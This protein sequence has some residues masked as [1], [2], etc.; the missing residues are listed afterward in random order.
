MWADIFGILCSGTIFDQPLDSERVNIGVSPSIWWVKHNTT[1]IAPE[2]K[3][4]D[5]AE[6]CW[7]QHFNCKAAQGEGADQRAWASR[8]HV[9]APSS[10]FGAICV[11][12]FEIAGQLSL[13]TIIM[14]MINGCGENKFQVVIMISMSIATFLN[15]ISVI[16]TIQLVLNIES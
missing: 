3:R 14:F 4:P 13:I 7:D 16:L 10:T 15:K 5:Q 2:A 6:R 12:H 11:L 8:T 9:S 1:Y